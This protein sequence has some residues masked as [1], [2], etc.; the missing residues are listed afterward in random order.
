MAHPTGECSNSCGPELF[1]EL[2]R[3]NEVLK[4]LEHDDLGPQP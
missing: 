2:E 3:W 1:E 4:A